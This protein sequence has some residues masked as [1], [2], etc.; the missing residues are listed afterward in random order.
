[1]HASHPQAVPARMEV[2]GS[3]ADYALTAAR[4]L[5]PGGMFVCVFPTPDAA[6]VV[7]ALDAAG[8]V[9]L[10]SRTI[11]FKAG[12]AF[13]LMLFAASRRA[14]LPRSFQGGIAGKPVVEP[15]LIIRSANGTTDPEYATVRLSFGFPP[16]D[17]GPNDA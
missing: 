14:D 15:P 5:A 4:I 11:V 6:R 12:E 3:V 8:L 16:G 9:L 13:G 17:V 2:R 1:M 7:D 10:R